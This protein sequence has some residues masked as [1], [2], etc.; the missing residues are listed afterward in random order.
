MLL[1]GFA[2]AV[3]AQSAPAVP[4]PVFETDKTPMSE[5]LARR[6]KVKTLIGADGVAV[7]FTNPVRNRNNDVDFLFRA[8]SSFLYLTGFEEPDAALLLAP[9]G[10]EIDG[11]RTTEVL[12]VNEP[13]RMSLTWLGYRMGSANTQTLLGMQTGLSNKRF[14]EVAR[15]ALQTYPKAGQTFIADGQVGTLRGMVNAFQKA[16]QDLNVQVGPRLDRAV[17]TMRGVK[18]PWEINIM[19]QACKISANAHVAVMKAIRPDQRE[20]EMEA[21]VQYMFGKHGC[22]YTGYPSICGSGPNSTILHYNSNRRQM[23]NGDIYCM[24]AAGEYHGY[25]ADVTRSFPVNGKFSP[26]QR[27]I[28]Q[29]VYEAQ[30]LGIS[31]CRNGAKVSEIGRAISDSM[32]AGLMKLGVIK[33]ASEI[34]RYYMHGF[35]HGLGLDVH[36]PMPSTLEPGVILTVEPGI[37]IK[38]D[39]PCDQK[40]WNIGIRIEDDIL[41][42]SGEPEN[43]SKDAP[44]TWQ[45]VEKTMAG[46]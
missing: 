38:A 40:W 27:A 46:K 3:F 39:S 25:T 28:Y 35:G 23:Q 2:P 21:L 20:Y 12:F 17:E 29:V 43:L 18:S 8:D 16:K 41:V 10:I 30:S 26:E 15:L 6:E 37:Y 9:G 45:D 5:L 22:E 44:R 32:A 14:E 24:D 33:E 42:T 7:F 11:R 19:R 34:R 1:L 13:D 31:L 4:Y 36:D